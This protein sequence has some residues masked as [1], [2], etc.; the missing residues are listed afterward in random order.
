MTVGCHP[1]RCSEFE[2]HKGGPEAY[3]NA[4]KGL[5]SD[6]AAKDKIV[7][8]GEC[9]LGKEGYGCL[10]Y[11]GQDHFSPSH[12]YISPTIPLLF[13]NATFQRLRSPLL[14]PESDTAQLL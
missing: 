9:G 1:T 3:F 7:A 8:I 10:L 6:P 11:L 5:L 14:L 13:S 4:L 2:K 12:I